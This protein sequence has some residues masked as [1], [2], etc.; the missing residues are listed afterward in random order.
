MRTKI[1]LFLC[2][3]TIATL[4]TVQEANADD[5]YDIMTYDVNITVN[6]DNT[7]D[8]I[9]TLLVDFKSQRHGIYR[10]IPTSK[11][12]HNHQISNIRVL[13]PDTAKKYK[14]DITR[15][16]YNTSILIGDEDVYV[17]G[18]VPYTIS[19]TYDIGPDFDASMDEFYFNLIGTQWD[20][21]I[22][23]VTFSVTMPHEFDLDKLNFTGGYEGSTDTTL[24]QYNVL[25]SSVTGKVVRPLEPFE[26]V[27]MALPLP[28]GYYQDVASYPN[29][30]LF[31]G[32]VL[33]FLILGFFTLYKHWHYKLNNGITPVVSFQP[34]KN[35]TPPE[36]AY[37]YRLESLDNK[38]ISTLILKWAS[39]GYL[40]ITDDDRRPGKRLTFTKLKEMSVDAPSFER[41]LFNDMFRIGNGEKVTTEKLKNTF[42]LSLSKAYNSIV[43]LFKDDK[44][45]LV[46]KVQYL[47][48]IFAVIC[49]IIFAFLLGYLDRQFMGTPFWGSILQA[50]ICGG[51]LFELIAVIVYGYGRSTN[52]WIKLVLIVQSLGVLTLL[53]VVFYRPIVALLPYASTYAIAS[54]GLLFISLI[55][56]LFSLLTIRAYTPYGKG[57]VGEIH[58]FRHFLKTAKV[59]QLEML[60]KDNPQYF[61]DI[62]PYAMVLDLSKKWG[63]YA[64]QLAVEPPNWYYSSVPFSA[65]VFSQTMT[66]SFSTASTS[67]SSSGS[68]SSSGGSSGGGSGGG[69]GGSW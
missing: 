51:L 15:S 59:D 21:A 68:S 39:E 46:N 49:T 41:Q 27:T 56:C 35:L 52:I 16:T 29:L 2:L 50:F 25:D 36:L 13:N 47:T 38:H 6:D 55:L 5:Y 69:G 28:E 23:E 67:P 19:Y 33:V 65:L 22:K 40:T 9:E 10:D 12:G 18:L 14:K 48:K 63:K 60:Y 42:Y 44:E 37:C 20:C 58:G 53:L 61:Y 34:P 66:R 8:I 54:V 4:F 32:L 24:V 62:L 17:E 7:Y 31:F 3:L 57:V 30:N 1:L 26:A 43:A 64:K 45:I 11:D